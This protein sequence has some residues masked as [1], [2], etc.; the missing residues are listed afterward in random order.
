[1]DVYLV[2]V[3]PDRFEC[4][5]EAAEQ[6]EPEEPVEGQG[7]FARMRGKFNEQ[8]KEAERARLERTIEEPQSF[9]GRM[10][11]R[12]LRWI[13]ERIAE[14]RLLWH[15]RRVD[16]AT[17]HTPAD[18]PNSDADAIMRASFKRDADHHRTR[19]ILHTLVLIA[20]VPVALVPGPNV[21]GYL[22]TFTVV[23]HFLAWRGA[24]RALHRIAWTLAP[25][26]AL[27]DLRRAFSADAA[28]RHRTILEVSQRLHLPKM[29]RFV[30]QMAAL[31]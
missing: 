30:E 19:L 6:D 24:V 15:L 11:K 18:L 14:Q 10:Q 13:A 16:T 12:S 9:L 17:L 29:A 5:Y 31:S 28:V 3:G 2:P 8:L 25:N 27:T 7:F 20:V 1:M 23:G 21:L 4:Y 26:P 22:F